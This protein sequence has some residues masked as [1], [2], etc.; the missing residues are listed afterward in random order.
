MFVTDK[1]TKNE[2]VGNE[3]VTFTS[4][5]QGEANEITHHSQY[6]SWSYTIEL[7]D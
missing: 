4:Q 7:I 3:N 6:H 2:T 1:V 5:Y